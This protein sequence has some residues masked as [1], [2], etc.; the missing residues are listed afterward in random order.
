MKADGGRG[1]PSWIDQERQTAVTN[2]KV[3]H[4]IQLMTLYSIQCKYLILLSISLKIL[5][6]KFLKYDMIFQWLQTNFPKLYQVLNFDD[7]SLWSSFSRSNECEKEF[8]SVIEKRISLFQQLLVVQA[9]RPDR[10]QTA[11]G[12]FACKALGLCISWNCHFLNL[13][14]YSWI[15]IYKFSKPSPIVYKWNFLIAVNFIKQCLF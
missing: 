12:L 2:L 4:Y 13:L 6:L 3:G 1:M 7:G 15:V 10:L 14:T 9:V 8:P 5:I 11:M